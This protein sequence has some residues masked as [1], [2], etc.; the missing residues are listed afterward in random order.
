MIK[1]LTLSALVL[2]SSMIQPASGVNSFSLLSV[3]NPDHSGIAQR[4]MARLATG[5]R[6]TRADDAS[7]QGAIMARLAAGVRLQSEIDQDNAQTQ[8]ARLRSLAEDA[9]LCL[10][11][12][13]RERDRN[14]IQ[15]HTFALEWFTTRLEELQ[16]TEELDKANSQRVRV[17]EM[18][19]KYL[20]DLSFQLQ[21]STLTSAQRDALQENYDRVNERQP[22]QPLKHR[23]Q[24]N[25]VIE[26]LEL[27]AFWKGIKTSIPSLHE[28]TRMEEAIRMAMQS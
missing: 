15:Q 24:M 16:D 21:D 2:A 9:R 1:G 20:R 28:M 17:E 3:K 27:K 23:I 6:I 5:H 13:Q 7:S 11:M 25:R 22:N 4:A 26:E 19:L 18:G 8:R 14:A 10:A 12:A